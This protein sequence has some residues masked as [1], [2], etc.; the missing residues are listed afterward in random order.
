MPLLELRNVSRHYGRLSAVDNVSL[1]IEAGEFF[2]LLG[3]SGCGK[4]TILR[5][6]AGFDAPDAGQI[7]LD[8]KDLADTPPEQRPLHTVFQSYALFPH[9]SV[10]ENV[11]FPLKMAKVAAGERTRLVR[12]ILEAVSLPDKADA[13]PHEL[14]GGQQQRVALARALVN[15][16]R[17]LLLDEPLAAL[18]HKLREQMQVELIGLQREVGITFVFVTH[19]QP[20]ALALSHRIA[21]MNQG[22]VEQLDEPSKIYAAPRNRFV[23][24]FIGDINLLECTLLARTEQELRLAIPDL[25]EIRAPAHTSASIGLA[26]AFAIRP[27]QVLIGGPEQHADLPNRFNGVVRELL[28]A[29]DVTTYTVEL[30]GGLRMQALLANVGAGLVKFFEVGDAVSVAWPASAGLFLDA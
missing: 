26:G 8:G 9:L 22:H 7:L 4:T 30:I 18:D 1:S 27:E 11:A 3:P 29:G 15:K 21:V 2:T 14:S 25:G 12:E 17:L 16:P 10:A 5:M 20:E 6:I 19:H 13:M 23:A 28:Y 24:H